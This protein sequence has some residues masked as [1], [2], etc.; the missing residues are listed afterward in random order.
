[1]RGVASALSQAYAV[2]E[3]FFFRRTSSPKRD[4]ESNASAPSD[5]FRYYSFASAKRREI[6]CRPQIRRDHP[7]N[8]SIS[9]SG[10]KETNEDSPSSGERNGNSPASNPAAPAGRREM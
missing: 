8:L 3:K 9:V 2:S 5:F 10:G 6:V 4:R 7:P 1:M